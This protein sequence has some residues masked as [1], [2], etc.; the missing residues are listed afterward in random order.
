MMCLDGCGQPDNCQ[1]NP[2]SDE[3]LSPTDP[4]VITHA[5]RII[6]HT[7]HRPYKLEN[8]ST[9]GREHYLKVARNELD[10]IAQDMLSLVAPLINRK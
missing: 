7:F 6:Q 2:A 4:I 5:E 8:L 1:C 10:D 3:E 9:L